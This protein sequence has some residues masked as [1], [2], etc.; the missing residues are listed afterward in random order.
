MMMERLLLT[1]LIL[2][3]GAVAFWAIRLFHR[4]LLA[5]RIAANG[6]PRLLYFRGESCAAC[7]TQSR[8]LSALEMQLGGRVRIE[9]IDAEAEPARAAAYAVFT[10]PTTLLV[11]RSGHVRHINYGLTAAGP[12]ARQLEEIA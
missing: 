2:A 6:Q 3:L 5:G 9:S 7:A 8:I 11:D 10:L 4:R 1:A 12:L